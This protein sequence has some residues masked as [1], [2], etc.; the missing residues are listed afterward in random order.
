MSQEL[1][2]PLDSPETQMAGTPRRTVAVR[3]RASLAA[4]FLNMAKVGLAM[5][6]H[7]KA[8]LVG[9]LLGVVFAVV[10][11]NQQVGT[12]LGLVQ[13]N[14]MLVEN[15][16][17]DIW[18]TP[19]ATESL[20]SAA[21]QT[22]N[23]AALMQAKTTPGV[24]F[25]EPILVTVGNITLPGGGT[26]QIQVVGTRLPAC[27]GGPWNLVA[28]SCADL[29]APDSIIIEHAERATLGG[30]NVGSV[31]EINNRKMTVVG[32]TWGLL[33]FGP[34]YS[35]TDFET[36]REL[37]KR[38]SDQVSFVLVGVEPGADIEAIKR[39]LQARVP[40]AKVMTKGDFKASILHD[41]LTRTAIGVT[42]GSSAVFGLIVGFVIVGLSMFSAV[43]DNVREFGT[44]KA[45]G[46]NNIDLAMLLF[47][48]SVTYACMGSLVGLA[49]VTRVAL[50]IRS[51]KLALVIPPWL[52]IS[53][54]GVMMFMCI[55]ASGLALLRIRKVEPAMVFR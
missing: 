36:A 15:A 51:A 50:G 19:N 10:L 37:S 55:F 3:R 28:G 35:F 41:L 24:S 20:V 23:T 1:T 12:F 49:L 46:C 7:D 26:Q 8:K 25:A 32:L 6:F 16:G 42:F 4:R 52:T 31:R 45:I 18:I 5:M 53:T 34:S 38:P 54:V 9:T 40:E 33:P 21:G 47:V 39:T 44:L 17:A 11:S 27:K 48:Q 2:V 13:K 30:M 29:A 22:L 14:V 43:V